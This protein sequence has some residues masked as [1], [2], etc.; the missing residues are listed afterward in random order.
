MTRPAGITPRGFPYPGSSGLHANT[1]TVLQALAEAITG[2]LSS[3]G[4]GVV[5][6][7]Y[8]GT[9]QVSA[10]LISLTPAIFTRLQ[11]VNGVVG[12][13]G[14]GAPGGAYLAGQPGG[15]GSLQLAIGHL[16]W[17]TATDRPYTGA[18]WVNLLA[19]GPSK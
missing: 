3:V 2:Q 4:V 15:S 1:P 10:N 6:D 7:F 13:C 9:V 18:L 11:T 5:F 19:W 14:V 17:V 12:N 8:A 16:D